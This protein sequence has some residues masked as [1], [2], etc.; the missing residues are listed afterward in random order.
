MPGLERNL[1]SDSPTLTLRGQRSDDLEH[2]FA[3]FNTDD[4]VRDSLDLP[5]PSEEAFR[6]RYGSLPAGT[7]ALV[8]EIGLPSGRKRIVGAVWLK[9][10][11]PFRRRHAAELRLA[12]HPDYRNTDTE[13]ALLKA[14]LELADHWLALRR[15]EVTVYV[16]RPET[17]DLYRRYGFEQEA[18]MRRYAFRA[19]AY[20]DA[21]LMARLRRPVQSTGEQN[22]QKG[23]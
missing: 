1:V 8:A 13:T 22:D 2:L 15:L 21:Y 17:V 7:Y 14:A 12:V 11:L 10:F 18:L 4:I 19:G 6:E 3:L 5:Y 20:Y 16:D 23:E 9:T